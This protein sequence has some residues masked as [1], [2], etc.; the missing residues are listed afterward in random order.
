M[1]CILISLPHYLPH[2]S[3]VVRKLVKKWDILYLLLIKLVPWKVARN[4]WFILIP[5]IFMNYAKS[6]ML[7]VEHLT[8]S[9]NTVIKNLCDLW[10]QLL[11][12]PRGSQQ[13]NNIFKPYCI[14]VSMLGMRK[15][16]MNKTALWGK[17]I[18]KRLKPAC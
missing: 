4:H 2:W 10:K 16:G 6:I 9:T 13:F 3:Q 12:S 15:T 17:Q 18:C 1:L 5:W 11:F 8:S 7:S 14:L